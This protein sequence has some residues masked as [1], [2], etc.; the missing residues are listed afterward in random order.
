MRSI[1]WVAFAAVLFLGQP[2]SAAGAVDEPITLKGEYYLYSAAQKDHQPVCSERRWFEDG[3]VEIIASGQEIATA[4]YRTERSDDADWLVQTVLKSNGAPDCIGR[5]RAADY[6]PVEARFYLYRNAVGG[7]VICVVADQK[8]Q[9][10]WLPTII[11]WMKPA[12][13]VVPPPA[14][15]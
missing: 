8:Y 12:S 7:I 2:A 9:G 10:K 5:Q 15:N 6:R 14:V 13:D 1:S 4:R 3:G 11:A